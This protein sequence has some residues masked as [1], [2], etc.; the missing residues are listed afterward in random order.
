M[1]YSTQQLTIRLYRRKGHEIKAYF[2]LHSHPHPHPQGK[3]KMY[4][5]V[6]H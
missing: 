4:Y 2:I 5:A 1:R 3:E 6:N